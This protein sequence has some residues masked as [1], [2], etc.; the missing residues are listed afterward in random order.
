MG[1]L[2]WMRLGDAVSQLQ[3][4]QPH[5]SKNNLCY[6]YLAAVMAVVG[7]IQTAH[8]MCKG[9]CGR[10][11]IRPPPASPSLTPTHLAVQSARRLVRKD[12]DGVLDKL[13]GEADAALLP[14]ADALDALGVIAHKHVGARIELLGSSVMQCAGV[15][16][17]W[18]CG[19]E[20][21]SGAGDGGELV[22]RLCVRV[23]VYR[24]NSV[25]HARLVATVHRG[26]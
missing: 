2:V 23:C 26:T 1:Y 14:A 3:C 24:D 13:N 8:N 16:Q 25:A 10:D 21:L 18:M 19:R 17:V 15:Q 4:A 22:M 11:S 7:L 6:F 5:C 12:D 20:G 9:C